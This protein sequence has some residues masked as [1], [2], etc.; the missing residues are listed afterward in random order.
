MAPIVRYPFAWA[1]VVICLNAEMRESPR[2][3]W[4]PESV[5]PPPICRGFSFGQGEGFGVKRKEKGGDGHHLL[6]R[7]SSRISLLVG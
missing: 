7:K 4:V 2:R 6:P 1:S 5:A 3:V